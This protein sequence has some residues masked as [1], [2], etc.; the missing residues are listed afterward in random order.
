MEWDEI[1]HDL[2]AEFDET[3][4]SQVVVDV[5]TDAGVKCEIWEDRIDG[6]FLVGARRAYGLTTWYTVYARNLDELVDSIPG[7][8][9]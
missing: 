7:M 2:P 3:R 8:V 6:D 5:V 9:S 4:F 1:G